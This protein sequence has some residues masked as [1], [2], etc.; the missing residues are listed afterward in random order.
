MSKLEKIPKA[1]Q[2]IIKSLLLSADADFTGGE[3]KDEKKL[4]L[5][6]LSPRKYEVPT[7]I[8]KD[9]SGYTGAQSNER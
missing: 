7:V 2:A 9:S 3:L 8:Y 1:L 5:T 4:A 6:V